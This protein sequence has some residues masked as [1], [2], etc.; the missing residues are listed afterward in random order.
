MRRRNCRAWEW[1]SKTLQKC[2][3]QTLKKMGNSNTFQSAAFF[4]IRTVCSNS[5]LNPALLANVEH[6]PGC[7]GTLPSIGSLLSLLTG[8]LDHTIYDF[9]SCFTDASKACFGTRRWEVSFEKVSRTD[10]C[11][12]QLP[13][14]ASVGETHVCSLSPLFFFLLLFLHRPTVHVVQHEPPVSCCL[15]V[16]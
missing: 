15:L 10:R 6:S 11:W 14:L 16:A 8:K 7:R 5:L 9:D 3:S 1:T 2:V 4:F 12:R 13:C